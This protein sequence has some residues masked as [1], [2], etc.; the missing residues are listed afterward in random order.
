MMGFGRIISTIVYKVNE[1]N[2]KGRIFAYN[3]TSI[4]TGLCLIVA[5]FLCDTVFS[6]AMFAIVFG[7][8]FG[9]NLSLRS[10][11]SYD[12]VGFEWSDDSLF[13][14]FAFSQ[15]VGATIGIPLAGKY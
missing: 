4:L 10:L 1:S 12:I 2:A 11:V 14:Y 9:F 13:S 5:T 15:A 7:V 6:C 3:L 8:L